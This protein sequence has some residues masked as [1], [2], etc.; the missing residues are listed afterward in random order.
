MH[1]PAT[2]PVC[3][4]RVSD[5]VV[6]GACWDGGQSIG[7]HVD[8]G[9]RAVRAASRPIWNDDWDSTLISV[10]GTFPPAPPLADQ[11]VD[12]AAKEESPFSVRDE[13]RR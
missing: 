11:Q 8:D 12:A 3:S 6:V 5:A 7:I 2:M 1:A 13:G 9:G 4:V 10:T